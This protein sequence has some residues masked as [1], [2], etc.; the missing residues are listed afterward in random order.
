[1]LLFAAHLLGTLIRSCLAPQ[2]YH[3]A[4]SPFKSSPR[5]GAATP[6]PFTW[7][8]QGSNAPAVTCKASCSLYPLSVVRSAVSHTGTSTNFVH[9]TRTNAPSKLWSL[10]SKNSAL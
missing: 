4:L 6:V 7:R 5:L 8:N 9:N 2:P 3:S 10:M 1:M